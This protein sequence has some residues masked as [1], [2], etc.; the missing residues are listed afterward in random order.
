MADNAFTPIY[1]GLGKGTDDLRWGWEAKRIHERLDELSRLCCP[2]HR[3]FATGYLR[4]PDADGD[5][6]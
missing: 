2:I 3:D 1:R 4:E 5:S 6:S